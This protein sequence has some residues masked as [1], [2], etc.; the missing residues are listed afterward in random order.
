MKCLVI[1][2]GYINNNLSPVARIK[3]LVTGFDNA[4]IYGQ[5]E[6]QVKNVKFYQ[7]DD[8]KLNNYIINSN[9]KKNIHSFD[10]YLYVY[11][12]INYHY[13][14]NEIKN[15][16][17]V[18]DDYKPDVI[19]S[20]DNIYAIIASKIANITCYS[21]YSS[22]INKKQTVYPKAIICINK[23]LS[24]YKLPQILC[25]ADLYDNVKYKFVY[26]SFDYQPI[27]DDNIIY[28]GYDNTYP[29]YEKNKV[30]VVSIANSLISAN[31]QLRVIK[32]TFKDSPY[33]V[34]IQNKN[35]VNQA[36]IHSNNK[37]MLNNYLSK[38]IVFIH[39]GSDINT[40]LALNYHMNQIIITNSFDH[41]ISN[42]N[43]MIK[44]NCAFKLSETLYNVK[45][46]YESFR[47]LLDNNKYQTNID[48]LAKSLDLGGT[49]KIIE[50]INGAVKK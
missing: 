21:S 15:I 10:E 31:K 7:S 12:M 42:A 37:L 16:L 29:V 24:Y 49:N 26:S 28:V 39:D 40:D 33:E 45:Y 19:F 11:K 32:Q 36:N 22:F 27:I 3:R 43:M 13:A 8:L 2:I 35:F 23:I 44:N 20:Y 4:A 1:P 17:K 46:L 9:N 25:I 5:K 41:H 6:Y 34:Y 48:A 47:A 14:I 18:I 50:T 38:A 30:I